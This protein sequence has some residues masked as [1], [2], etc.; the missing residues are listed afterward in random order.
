MTADAIF[1]PFQNIYFGTHATSP[2][3]NKVIQ[4]FYL[5]ILDGAAKMTMVNITIINDIAI[6]NL[7]INNKYV[8]IS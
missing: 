2:I 1:L 4:N 6:L 8:I 5:L 3:S 7:E